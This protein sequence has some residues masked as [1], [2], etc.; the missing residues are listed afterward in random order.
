[1][2]PTRSKLTTST[3]QN[4]RTILL[5]GATVISDIDGISQLKG[6]NVL[7]IRF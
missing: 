7:N 1:M 3:V 4:K 6:Q 2:T 5:I